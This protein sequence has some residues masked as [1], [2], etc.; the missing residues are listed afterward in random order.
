MSAELN[1]KCTAVPAGTGRSPGYFRQR[2]AA[3][4]APSRSGGAAELLGGAGPKF[5][6]PRPHGGGGR[7]STAEANEQLAHISVPNQRGREGRLQTRSVGRFATS[8]RL[9]NDDTSPSEFDCRFGLLGSMSASE[10]SGRSPRLS[11]KKL[12]N[13]DLLDEWSRLVHLSLC[14]PV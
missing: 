1:V 13:P 3:G 10:T 6:M 2:Y 12:R 9:C 4:R 5:P 14:A 11:I 8:F 7:A